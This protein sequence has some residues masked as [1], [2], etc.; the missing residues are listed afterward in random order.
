M[1]LVAV[2]SPSER[3]A[4]MLAKRPEV[5]VIDYTGSTRFGEQLEREAT[6]AVVFTE[7]AGVNCV[8]IDSTDD[9]G[10]M[11][12]NLAFTLSLYSGQMCTTTQNIYVPR[13]GIDTDAGH[14]TFDEVGDRSGRA[15]S[16]NLLSRP[17]PSRRRARCD[18]LTTMS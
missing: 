17:R 1:S 7:K 13:D 18:R 2:A 10:A 8:V 4:G 15:R 14:K 9:Y 12:K 3:L 11:L 6:H 16:T 5:R